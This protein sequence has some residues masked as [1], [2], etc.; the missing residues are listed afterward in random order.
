M[1]GKERTRREGIQMF[2]VA[3]A[4]GAVAAFGA[5]GVLYFFYL[6]TLELVRWAAIWQRPLL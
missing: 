2:G 3:A 6:W 4:A 1:T 5:G